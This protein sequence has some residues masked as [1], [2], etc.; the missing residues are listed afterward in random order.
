[1]L[2]VDLKDPERY[3]R[4]KVTEEGWRIKYIRIEWE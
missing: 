2:V 1:V 3:I 4:K